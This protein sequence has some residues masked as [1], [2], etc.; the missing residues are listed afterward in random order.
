MSR[1]GNRARLGL[2]SK[3]LNKVQEENEEVGLQQSLEKSYSTRERKGL[4][5]SALSE[6]SK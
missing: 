3:M 1:S 2:L 4:K 5:V 6:R